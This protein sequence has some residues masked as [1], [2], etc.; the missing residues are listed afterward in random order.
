MRTSSEDRVRRQ[1][2]ALIRM[3]GSPFFIS[4]P[5]WNWSQPLTTV[6]ERLLTLQSEGQNGPFPSSPG[7]NYDVLAAGW[8]MGQNKH[9]LQWKGAH[10]SMMPKEELVV[11]ALRCIDRLMQ[12]GSK[13]E[14]WSAGVWVIQAFL[15]SVEDQG[16]KQWSAAM[17]QQC[18]H[19]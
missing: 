15:R 18:Y 16:A 7:M 13:S 17:A 4:M 8:H 19:K 14:F 6:E 10:A 12:E 1:A 9:V 2:E 11:P 5:A 3:Q